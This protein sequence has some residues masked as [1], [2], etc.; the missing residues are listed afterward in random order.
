MRTVLVLLLIL[1]AL[2]AGGIYAYMR[3]RPAEFAAFAMESRR[4]LA[5]LHRDEM[6]IPGFH[7]VY[8]E[9][10]E[11]E[12]LILL[13]GFGADKDNWTPVSRH[14]SHDF[15]IIAP[16]LP[17]FGESDKPATADY[18]IEGQVQHLAAFVQALHLDRFDLGGSSMGGRIAAV[19]ASAHPNQVHTLWLLAP[20]GVASAKPSEL[21]Q[22]IQST[23]SNPLLV[24]SPEDFQRLLAFVFVHQP[25]IPRP[26][27]DLLAR[28]AVDNYALDQQI[29]ATDQ[30]SPPLEPQIK[31]LSIP[32]F[33]TWGD[34]DRI[35]DVSGA[36]VLQKLVPHVR[37][38]I[39]PDV[40]H[41]PMLETPRRT[42]EGY[43]AF[44]QRAAAGT[45]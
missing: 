35:L 31:G 10:G 39:L 27:L 16:D 45:L 15:R 13:H 23:G 40:G 11:G 12:P 17:G 25:R 14:L 41:A 30:H 6:N 38:D 20:A 28:R 21:A 9:G 33:I 3:L 44:R 37:V 4:S 24:K 42:A 34:H 29:F 8:L 19:Y 7:L 26:V 2:A 18:S 32:T 22:L 5:G 43:L 36:A 1:I